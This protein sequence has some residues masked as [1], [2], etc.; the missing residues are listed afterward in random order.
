MRGRP[1][2]IDKNNYSLINLNIMNFFFLHLLTKKRKEESG[3]HTPVSVLDSDHNIT[4]GN[5]FLDDAIRMKEQPLM[6]AE[7]SVAAGSPEGLW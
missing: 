4:E 5:E 2:Q 7:E 3:R 1:E 6:Y